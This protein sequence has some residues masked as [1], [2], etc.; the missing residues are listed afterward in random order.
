MN[1]DNQ[2]VIQQFFDI[3]RKDDDYRRAWKDNIAMAF[4][5]EFHRASIRNKDGDMNEY[6]FFDNGVHEIA[7][8]AADNFLNML[9][10]NK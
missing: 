8:T 2:E 10:K 7:N 4:K 1:I 3:L 6:I 5:D 9:I